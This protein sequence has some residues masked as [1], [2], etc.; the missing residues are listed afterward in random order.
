LLSPV[1]NWSYDILED[2]AY[3]GNKKLAVCFDLRKGC[4]A[5]SFLR[6]IMKTDDIR[7]Y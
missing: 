7:N 2:E 4:Y 3:N 1:S 6:E 5:T